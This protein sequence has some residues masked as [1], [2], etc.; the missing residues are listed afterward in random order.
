MYLR[1]VAASL[2][3]ANDA[4]LKGGQEKEN[5]SVH[6]R[7]GPADAPRIP[8][9]E[10]LAL[11]PPLDLSQSPLFQAHFRDS[12]TPPISPR[13]LTRNYRTMS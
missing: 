12:P 10:F 1:F 7:G 3:F 9:G 13:S 6:K 2:R 8:Q 4:D 5:L 11:E